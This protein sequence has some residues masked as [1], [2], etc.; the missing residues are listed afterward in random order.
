MRSTEAMITGYFYATHMYII[1]ENCLTGIVFPPKWEELS[2]NMTKR[3]KAIINHVVSNAQ[4]KYFLK[5]HYVQLW[6]TWIYL[7]ILHVRD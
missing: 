5:K 7:K 1:S 3:K 6:I 4:D 2:E